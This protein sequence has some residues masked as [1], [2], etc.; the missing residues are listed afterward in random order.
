MSSTGLNTW[1][2]RLAVR[3]CNAILATVASREYRDTLGEVILKGMTRN[4]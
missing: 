4:V 2:N 1:R 3:L